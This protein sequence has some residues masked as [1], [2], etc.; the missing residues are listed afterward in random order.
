MG[1]VGREIKF[2][3][4]QRRLRTETGNEVHFR[5]DGELGAY[6]GETKKEHL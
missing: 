1:I 5:H 2:E 6:G 4:K 3:G